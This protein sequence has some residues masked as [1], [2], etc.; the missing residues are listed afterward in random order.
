MAEFFLRNIIL[1]YFVYSNL[2]GISK[3]LLKR[4]AI[5]PI[6]GLWWVHLLVILMIMALYYLP[7]LWHWRRR[8]TSQQILTAGP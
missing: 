3:T 2:L 6:L 8:D 4:D 7:S 5:D 1:I